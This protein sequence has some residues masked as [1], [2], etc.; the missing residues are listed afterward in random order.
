MPSVRG[1][2]I[3]GGGGVRITREFNKQ[4][5]SESEFL[6]REGTNVSKLSTKDCP[7]WE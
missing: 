5:E 7:N 6:G 2:A 1:M 4:R 3:N